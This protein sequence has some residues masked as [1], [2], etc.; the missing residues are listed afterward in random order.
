M[1]NWE[2][3]TV[4]FRSVE[5]TC[6]AL[7]T[8]QILAPYIKRQESQRETQLSVLLPPSP[9]LSI[10]FPSKIDPLGV[11]RVTFLRHAGDSGFAVAWGQHFPLLL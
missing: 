7:G 9:M 11:A 1:K 6:A 4:L 8:D 5:L 3:K 10:P 2:E